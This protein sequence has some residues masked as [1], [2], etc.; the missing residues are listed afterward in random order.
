MIA[1]GL[2]FEGSEVDISMIPQDV[3]LV[4]LLF[5]SGAVLLHKKATCHQNIEEGPS[6]H[7][8]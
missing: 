3:A 8:L 7:S 4:F 6:L 1:V 2:N 5:C